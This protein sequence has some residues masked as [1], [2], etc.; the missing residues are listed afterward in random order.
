MEELRDAGATIVFISHNMW[1]I[2]SFCKRV[3]LL[4]AGQVK[5]SGD[6]SE[7]IELYRR[8]EREKSISA[9]K[10]NTES[11]NQVI[12]SEIE[13][14]N[15]DQAKAREF[16]ASEQ[17]RVKIHYQSPEHIERPGFLVQIRRADGLLCC[18]VAQ[19]TENVRAIQGEGVI[20]A[21]IGPLQLMPDYY[22]VEV[23]LVDRRK[24][25]VYANGYGGSFLVKGRIKD[26]NY[27]PVFEPKV[28]WQLNGERA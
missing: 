13:L 8:Q 3:I 27:S 9:P 17:L 4:D 7:M 22:N 10:D 24:P 11:T 15:K 25:I 5:G 1:S 6:P 26:S 12:F 23:R 21:C 2:E 19:E 14:F 18:E 28:Q 16:D 20:E